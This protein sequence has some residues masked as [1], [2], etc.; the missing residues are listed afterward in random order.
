MFLGSKWLKIVGNEVGLL[1]DIELVEVRQ[2]YG[3][4]V[5]FAFPISAFEHNE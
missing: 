2:R 1:L 4:G 3:I 5:S